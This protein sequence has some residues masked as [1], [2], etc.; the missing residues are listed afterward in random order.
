M[1]PGWLTKRS[2]EQPSRGGRVPAGAVRCGGG[3]GSVTTWL[4]ARIAAW[5]YVSVAMGAA[6][7]WGWVRTR[8]LVDEGPRREGCSRRRL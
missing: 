6:G 5:R 2:R 3:P 1:G 4:E 7:G 8:F